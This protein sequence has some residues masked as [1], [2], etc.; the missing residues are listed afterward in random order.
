M[1]PLVESRL[2]VVRDG[3]CH[4]KFT[5][6]PNRKK[7]LTESQ[8]TLVAP[9][10]TATPGVNKKILIIIASWLVT[11]G[12]TL[13]TSLYT[14][15]TV[16]STQILNTSRVLQAKNGAKPKNAIMAYAA[17][18][19]SVSEVRTQ[20]TTT[21]ARPTAIEAYLKAYNSP[22]IG[23][24]EYI[25]KTS[26]KHHLDPY[27]IVAIA[28]QESNLC[29][30]IPNDSYNCWGWGIHSEGTLKFTSYQ[31]AIQTVIRGL[32]EN[33]FNKG[34]DSPEEI[35]AKYTPQSNGSWAMGVNQFLAELQTGNF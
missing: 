2:T 30:I 31:Q 1:Q 28:Q 20:I 21:D 3:F 9:T 23:L 35:M 34:Y 24:A 13:A 32:K 15:H 29:K 6:L 8:P 10:T 17:L 18:P 7:T 27:L 22:L 16:S 14:L 19:A 33:Y 26:D 11:T 4:M 12:I 5:R 25:V